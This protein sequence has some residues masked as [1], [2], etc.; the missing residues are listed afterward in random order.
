MLIVLFWPRF[1]VEWTMIDVLG[2]GV[3]RYIGHY[4]QRR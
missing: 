2:R 4:R 3:V 1:H